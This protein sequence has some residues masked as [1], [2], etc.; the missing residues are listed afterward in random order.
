MNT[1]E[2]FKARAELD[3]ECLKVLEA[4]G[5]DYAG[6]SAEN[7][8]L[9]NFKQVASLLAMFGVNP[10]TPL[11][12][13]SIYWLKHVFAIL[14]Y[15]GQHTESEPIIQRFVDARNYLD[16]GWGLV[17]E[18]KSARRNTGPF[19]YCICLFD[20]DSGDMIPDQECIRHGI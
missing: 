7:D 19:D 18:Q 5:K 20:R 14:A 8:R 16:L 4:K 11:G 1:N 15:I 9:G 2:L 3:A 13:W 17:S 6:S 10:S 12:V